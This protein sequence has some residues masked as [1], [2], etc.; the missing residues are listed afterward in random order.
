MENGPEVADAP[1]HHRYEARVA[2]ELAGVAEYA[3]RRDQRIFLHTTVTLEGH[4]VGGALA[5]AALDD[6]RARGMRAV[7]KCP[8]IAAWI[9]RHPDYV[10]LVPEDRRDLLEERA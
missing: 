6:V 5:R 2:G 7:P 8:F 9:R 10:D 1:D 3:D 4:G